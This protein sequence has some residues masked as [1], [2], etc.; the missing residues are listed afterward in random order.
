M[1]THEEMP[2]GSDAW[3]AHRAKHYNASDA[4]A[5]LGISPYESRTELL[6]RLATGICKEVDAATQRRF[7]DGHRCEALARPIAEKII[8]SKLYPV[9]VS[10]GNLSASLDGLTMNEKTGFE[11]KRVNADIRRVFSNDEPLLEYHRV[12]MEQQ[13]L[14]V[15]ECESILF[16]ATE[17]D[18][19]G[20]LV[21]DPLCRW[22]EPDQNMRERI[23]V[24]WDQFEKD[25]AAYV[26]QEV[27]IAAVGRTPDALPALRIEVTGMV[28]ASN[29]AE[30]KEHSL[31]VFAA[32]NTDLQTDEDFASAEKTVKWC[33]DVE[34]RLEAA[35]QHALSQTASIDDLFRA[36][37]SIKAEAR[38][39]RLELDKLVKARKDSIR[40]EIVQAA[41]DSLRS[42]INKLNDRLGNCYMVVPS[43][44]FA[45]AI[46]GLKTVTSLHNAADTALANA[47]IAANE[48][49]DRIEINLRTLHEEA[50]EYKALFPD[51]NS[52][53]LKA[54]EDVIATMKARIADH[55]AAEAK[56]EEEARQRIRAE[57]EKRAQEK[58]KAEQEAA[59]KSERVALS[60]KSVADA[61]AK[62][63]VDS[64]GA[65]TAITAVPVENLRAAVVEHGDDIREFL[66]S[67]D[68][69]DKR[70]QEIRPYLVAYVK[71]VAAGVKNAKG[72]INDR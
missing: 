50:G 29:L 64:V 13:L 23:I 32:I 18:D 65:D 62:V 51:T 16:M 20:K 55:K 70:R 24:G 4:P 7:D 45:S 61:S 37:D 35:K 48:V 6:H 63:F 21:G 58:V 9:V 28:T 30:F 33:G 25:L 36:I 10:E 46:K 14:I 69:P 43:V 8:G 57:E 17:W 2:Q 15:E 31:A 34:E 59:A 42:H 47:K 11:H 66:N 68:V 27:V 22:Y 54:Q 40:V 5:M 72:P 12:Q 52:L 49:A 44:D 41:K 3:H 39:K 1:I 71:W 67:L 38:A 56:R 26:P 53:V 19:D 60:E